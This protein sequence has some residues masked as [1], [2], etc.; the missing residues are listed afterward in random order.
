MGYKIKQMYLLLAL[1]SLFG[2][3]AIALISVCLSSL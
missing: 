3:S 1:G 2:V